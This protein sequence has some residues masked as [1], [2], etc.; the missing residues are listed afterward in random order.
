[1]NPIQYIQAQAQYLRY[2][3]NF[4]S[5]HHPRDANKSLAAPKIST[6]KQE[7]LNSSPVR[8]SNKSNPYD[9]VP[10]KSLSIPFEKLLEKEL[11]TNSKTLKS[12]SSPRHSYLKRTSKNIQPSIKTNPDISS[13]QS[14][15]AKYL[16]KVDESSE[17]LECDEKL[18]EDIIKFP[19]E[20]VRKSMTSKNLLPIKVQGYP[21]TS[22][23]SNK[24]L[25]RGEGKLCSN[26]PKNNQSLSSFGLICK[27]NPNIPIS[28]SSPK[29]QF[30]K[31]N[32]PIKFQSSQI[33]FKSLSPAHSCNR[34]KLSSTNNTQTAKAY[35]KMIENLES[36]INR[37]KTES[38]KFRKLK[39]KEI[40]S[41]EIRKNQEKNHIL[42]QMKS[43]RNLKTSKMD[44][45]Q[46][47]NMKNEIKKLSDQI[48]KNEEKYNG[49]IED[50]KEVIE[51]LSNQNSDL[52]AQLRVKPQE[53]VDSKSLINLSDIPKDLPKNQKPDSK[54][55][56]K[57][58][59]TFTLKLPG[60]NQKH[61]Y[62]INNEVQ[63]RNEKDLVNMESPENEDFGDIKIL[64]NFDTFEPLRP[65]KSDLVPKTES[66]QDTILP[67]GTR[68]IIF[69]NG[70]RKE[71]KPDG[72]VRVF[73][74]NKDKKELFTDGRTVYHF[75]E[76]KTI[77][78]SFPDG[79]IMLEFE[80][81]QI[82]KHFPDGSKEVKFSDGTIKFVFSNGEEEN[83]Y[84]DG[85]LDKVDRHGVRI[86]EYKNGVKDTIYLDGTRV[87]KFTDGNFRKYNSKGNLI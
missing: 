16:K 2:L 13:S 24:Y 50:L 47:E 66:K 87:R 32:S 7:S 35:S 17:N 9:E 15:L 70:V 75:F 41:L 52:L 73:F 82:E 74:K 59:P 6:L 68:L 55:E 30:K 29:V 38:K 84:T 46:L 51:E 58:P 28:K 3:A 4:Y 81:G 31:L 65:F 5:N 23:E 53:Y 22:R 61:S 11:K 64:E 14:K 33:Q 78:S 37:I 85:T 72:F 56:N 67:D 19:P 69:S 49:Y 63:E 83:Q 57:Y 60:S 21:I 79:L 8:N 71:I 43:L 80:N 34:L 77:Q 36:K 25:K 86:V 76:S 18:K 39:E 27:S 10:I 42:N 44:H 1:M 26:S 45:F 40:K 62:E 20:K 48:D 12:S 54:V